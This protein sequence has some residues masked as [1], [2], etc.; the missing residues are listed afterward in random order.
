M[1]NG[2][3]H[4]NPTPC[5]CIKALIN[6][7][8]FL[9]AQRIRVITGRHSTGRG[10]HILEAKRFGQRALIVARLVIRLHIN[11]VKNLWSNK[12]RVMNTC[13]CLGARRCYSLSLNYRDPRSNSPSS[14]H[15]ILSYDSGR[16][17]KTS[18]SPLHTTL[19]T[20]AS[21]I[22]AY[23]SSLYRW[24]SCDVCIAL[25]VCAY[26]LNNNVSHQN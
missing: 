25:S 10:D 17:W 13:K 26:Q 11:D 2:P 14:P 19:K 22:A 21:R 23:R 24:N 9:H 3:L 16:C 18:R 20:L 7:V 12:T 15:L 6:A 5:H 1:K 8:C 4:V